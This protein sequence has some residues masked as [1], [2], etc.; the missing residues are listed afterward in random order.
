LKNGGEVGGLLY[1]KHVEKINKNGCGYMAKS[2]TLLHFARGTNRASQKTRN[3][4][5]Y[6]GTENWSYKDSKRM[7]AMDFDEKDN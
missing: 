3:R 2:G 5:S 4:D 1:E 7:A 6:D